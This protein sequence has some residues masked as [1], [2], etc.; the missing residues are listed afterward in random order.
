MRSHF[1]CL[2]LE[3]WLGST[4]VVK[5]CWVRRHWPPFSVSMGWTLCSLRTGNRS[6]SLWEGMVWASW[7]AFPLQWSWHKLCLGGN[8]W[9]LYFQFVLNTYSKGEGATVVLLL[10]RPWFVCLSLSQGVVGTG[11]IYYNAARML[12]FCS[13][14]A[15][16]FPQAGE[17]HSPALWTAPGGPSL[18]PPV[19]TQ[20]KT[21]ISYYKSES[22]VNHPGQYW[23]GNAIY[24]Y[25]V[26]ILSWS[27]DS[28]FHWERHLPQ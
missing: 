11:V 22:P 5:T 28:L 27:A 19:C 21:F 16:S 4:N 20:Y 8:F 15:P 9:S 13:S 6:P 25:I 12:P 2:S 3:H 1:F 14:V 18:T 24:F 17:L 10:A 7:A 23:K 26:Y